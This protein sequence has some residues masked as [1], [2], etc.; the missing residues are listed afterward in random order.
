[1]YYYHPEISSEISMVL[2][3]CEKEHNYNSKKKSRRKKR[4]ES[5]TF[6]FIL[7]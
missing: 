4:G 6:D 5:Q 2:E 1:M 3:N 7:L